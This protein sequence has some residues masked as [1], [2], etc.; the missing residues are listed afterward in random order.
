[1]SRIE[2]QTDITT[3]SERTSTP[4]GPLPERS[5]A[6]LYRDVRFLDEENAL[7][8]MLAQGTPEQA[9]PLEESLLKEATSANHIPEGL[10]RVTFKAI[11]TAHAARQLYGAEAADNTTYTHLGGLLERSL[12]ERTLLMQAG[13]SAHKK[14]AAVLTGTISEIAVYALAAYDVNFDHSLTKRLRGANPRYVL[15]STSYEDGGRIALY[16]SKRSTKMSGVDL[17]VT[18]LEGENPHRL[19]Q[20]KTRRESLMGR[21]YNPNIVV[22]A[23]SSL[24]SN[25]THNPTLIPEAIINDARGDNRNNS[26]RRINVAS[27]R[28]NRLIQ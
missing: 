20:V 21:A 4:L 27:Q 26:Y 8:T 5:A 9:F 1:M 16:G 28:L 19:V 18:Y 23:L 11:A 7:D 17:K 3:R 14:E 2:H 22:V 15:P 12:Q 24:L 13:E 25:P 10:A 6:F